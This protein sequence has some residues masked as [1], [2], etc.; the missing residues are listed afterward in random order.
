MRPQDAPPPPPR[1]TEIG[2]DPD[3]PVGVEPEPDERT[4]VSLGHAA[5]RFALL[6]ML[7]IAGFVAV[8]WTPL[9]E[10]W[11]PHQLTALLQELRRTWW[12]PLALLGLYLVLCPIGVPASPM[13]IAGG[14]VF[15]AVIGGLLNFVGTFLGAAVSFFL[16]HLLGRDLV[17]HVV[18]DRLRPVE[19]MLNRQGFWNLARVRFVPIPFPVV[20]YGAALAG[21]KAPV[22]LGG[23]ALGLAPAVF[24]YTWFASALARATGEERGAVILQMALAVAGILLLSFLPPLLRGWSRRRRYRRLTE[25]RRSRKG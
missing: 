14:F 18:G 20:N 16:G 24:I 6:A 1:T 21:V 17:V 23:T 11:D 8:R 13:I 25:E 22:F 3:P 15:G 10:Y 12:A 9:A 5:L 2:R 4:G 7:L 19:E